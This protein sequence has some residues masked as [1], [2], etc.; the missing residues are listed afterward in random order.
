MSE[1]IQFLCL[2]FWILW[3]A[4]NVLIVG[5]F[6]WMR[7]YQPLYETI[8]DIEWDIKARTAYVLL[9]IFVLSMWW[10]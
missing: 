3:T 4:A 8:V 2:V 6:I 7:R 1:F 9:T 10:W 5:L